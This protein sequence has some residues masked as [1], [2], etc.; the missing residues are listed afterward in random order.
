MEVDATHS[1]LIQENG[2]FINANGFVGAVQLELSHDDNFELELTESALVADFITSGNRGKL[3]VVA[4][5]DT[6][7]FSTTQQ[8]EI[9][10][11]IVANS[12]SEIDVSISTDLVKM[13]L[14]LI[15]LIPQLLLC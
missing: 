11:A 6:K 13:L 1:K 10:D 5:G 15:H 3:I 12:S 9:V 8:F 4:P 14:I 2:V 7:L